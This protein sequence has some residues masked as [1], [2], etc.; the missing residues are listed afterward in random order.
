MAD[1]V[2]KLYAKIGFKV[3]KKGITEA[4][5]LLEDLAAKMTAVNESTKVIAREYGIFNKE[6][7]KATLAEEKAATQ[8]EKTQSEISKRGIERE[9]FKHRQLMDFAKLENEVLPLLND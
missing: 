5:S 4:K 1:A 6:R 2:S 9:R 7:A 3:D 8:R